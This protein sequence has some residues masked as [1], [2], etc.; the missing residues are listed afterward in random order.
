MNYKEGIKDKMEIE[1]KLTRREVSH[2]KSPHTF[3]DGC[4]E[5]DDVM[6]KVQK[7]IDKELKRLKK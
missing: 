2:L 4:Q 5:Q 3:Y 6:R 7:E 1:I